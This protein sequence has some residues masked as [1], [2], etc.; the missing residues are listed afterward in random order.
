M[1]FKDI[2]EF[3]NLHCKRNKLSYR[4]II[5]EDIKTV[6]N[7]GGLANYTL[8]LYKVKNG[9]SLLIRTFSVKGK[10]SEVKAEG[11]YLFLEAL[12]KEDLLNGD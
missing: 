8:D 5:R 10:I 12:S 4:Y 9:K 1:D 6:N 11:F 3:L 2:Q 7:F